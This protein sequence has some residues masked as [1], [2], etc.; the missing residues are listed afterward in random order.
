MMYYHA[1]TKDRFNKIV[2]D[3][4]I[5][6]GID[7]IVY[8]TTSKEDALKFVALR[9]F[10]DIVVMEIDG[11]DDSKVFETFDHSE[12]FF[13]CKSYGYADNIPYDMISNAWIYSR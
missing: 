8:L 3:G 13:K 10:D 11:L 2:S 9:T 5:K 7:H 12:Q 6:V 1:T 4:L